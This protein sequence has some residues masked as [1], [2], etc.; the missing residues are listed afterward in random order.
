MMGWGGCAARGVAEF[1]TAFKEMPAARQATSPG[2]VTFTKWP[3]SM[4]PALLALRGFLLLILTP[5]SESVFKEMPSWGKRKRYKG[6]RSILS[7]GL[8][9]LQQH[10]SA[11]TVPVQGAAQLGAA[12]TYNGRAKGTPKPSPAFNPIPA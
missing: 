11:T 7:E 1:K 6:L 10:L 5:C 8:R 3:Y 9:P 2:P 4:L 12:G